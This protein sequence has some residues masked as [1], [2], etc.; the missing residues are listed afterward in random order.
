[1]TSRHHRWPVTAALAL[2]IAVGTAVSGSAQ[3]RG[4]DMSRLDAQGWT[5]VEHFGRT[6]CFNPG[7]GFPLGDP[8]PNNTYNF[9]TFDITT[10]EFR[11]T[12]HWI[13]ADLYQGQPCGPD[14]TP[15]THLS[16]IGYY[17]CFHD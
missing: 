16:R 9:L 12:G 13:R 17:Q 3:A 15:Y 8:T 7:Q 14:G 1:M 4:P 10:G 6:V 2:A 5:C 11:G